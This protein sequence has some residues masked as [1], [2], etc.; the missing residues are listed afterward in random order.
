VVFY[1]GTAGNG[2][3]RSPD[4][5]VTWQPFSTGFIAPA[6]TC[7]EADPRNPRRLVACTQGGGLL[8]IQ[9]SPGS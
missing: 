6:V 3:W 7:L 5:G 9:I 4:Q 1:A 2:V 8:E